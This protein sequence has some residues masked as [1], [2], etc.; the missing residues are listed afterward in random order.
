MN[1]SL[2]LGENMNKIILNELNVQER[3]VTYTYSVEGDFKKFF[4]NKNRYSIKYEYDISSVP[5]GILA[6]PFV[7]NILPMIWLFDAKLYIDNLDSKF[8]RSIDDIKKAYIKMYPQLNFFGEVVVKNIE[9][10]NYQG[11][12]KG[13]FFSG[14]LDATSTLI[15]HYEEKP[16]LINIQGSDLSTY[17]KKVLKGVKSYLTDV[18]KDFGLDITFIKSEF[19]TV[20]KEKLVTKHFYELVKDNY[21]HG[22]QHGIAIISHAAPIAYIQK[23]ELI[24]IAASYTKESLVPCASDPTIDNKVVLSNTSI[25]HDGFEL[26][27]NGKSQ[28][29]VDFI[30]KTHK[31]IKLR[32]CYEDYRI[33]NCCSCEKCY[34]TIMNFCAKD[35][36]VKNIGFNLNDNNFKKMES[37]I[38]NRIIF[39]TSDKAYWSTI[40]KEFYLH[41]NLRS[42]SRF[43]WVY[44]LD[45]DGINNNKIK[46]VKTFFYK[47]FR[48]VKKVLVLILNVFSRENDD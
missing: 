6:I 33:E 36:D 25:F 44:D 34:R 7:A 26:D 11:K 2:N 24:Y 18:A 19:R 48:R 5:M 42:D 40:K 12:K 17:Y 47:N 30:N 37:D 21:W 9:K 4:K 43:S 13:L 10:N 14:G 31:K 3:V 32:V 16:L 39:T 27:R 1:G 29:V 38:K 23:L 28:N 22:F 46:K 45:L 35:F 15:T 8:F 20:I 41:P